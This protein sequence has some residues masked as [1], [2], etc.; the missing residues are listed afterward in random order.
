[1]TADVCRIT[2]GAGFWTPHA[3]QSNPAPSPFPKSSRRDNGPWRHPSP[4]TSRWIGA[5]S[6]GDGGPASA[7]WE[8]GDGEGGHPTGA[9]VE[10]RDIWSLYS[11]LWRH[12]RFPHLLPSSYC[13]R[14]LRR[15]LGTA[16]ASKLPPRGTPQSAL[17]PSPVCITSLINQAGTACQ[18]GWWIP[19]VWL[20]GDGEVEAF[21]SFFSFFLKKAKEK[22]LVGCTFCEREN[23]PPFEFLW[24][25]K[26]GYLKTWRKKVVIQS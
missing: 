5:V 11:S 2:A 15:A 10:A 17:S 12:E 19:W 6:A 13:A 4:G 14:G 21:F 20:P 23:H 22:N 3:V 26:Y 25:L 7:R 1:M 16:A 24:I 18:Q 8:G 9:S